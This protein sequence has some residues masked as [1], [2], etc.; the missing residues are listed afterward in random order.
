V[1]RVA[2]PPADFELLAR[3]GAALLGQLGRA[4]EVARAQ[5]PRRRA[6]SK[7]EAAESLGVSIDFFEQHIVPELRIVYRGR[8]RLI[9]V[10]ELDRWLEDNATAKPV[11][12]PTDLGSTP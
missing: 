3:I 12:P 10:T 2:P 7:A 6:L 4:S 11:P 5:V 8:R 1:D 9:P